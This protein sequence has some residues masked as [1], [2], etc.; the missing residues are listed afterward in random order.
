[1]AF[2]LE[3]LFSL[4]YW[5]AILG[6]IAWWVWIVRKSRKAPPPKRSTRENV[7]LASLRALLSEREDTP[8]GERPRG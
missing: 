4:L 2:L 3:N 1:M 6:G 5:I 7:E 8:K